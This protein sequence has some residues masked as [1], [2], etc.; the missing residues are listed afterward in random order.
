MTL[1]KEEAESIIEVVNERATE[2]RQLI[3]TIVSIIAIILPAAEGMGLVDL[4]PYGEGDDEWVVDDNWEMGSDF[5][6]GD[7]TTIQASLVD[8]G[9]KNCR[10]GSDEPDAPPIPP[11]S[12]NNTTVITEPP[13]NNN[14]NN[15]T[16]EEDCIAKM[17]D[18][19]ILD[20]NGT[21]LT[22][23]W[24][25]DL[26]CEEEAYN[27]TVVWTVYYNATGNFTSQN[28]VTYETQGSAWDYVNI[29]LANVTNGV[30]DIHSTF[31]LGDKYTRGTDWYAVEVN[32][33]DS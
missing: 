6:C 28:E 1:T 7:G 5:T 27:L 21:N 9:Y 19:Y 29:T 16:I 3:I 15:E 2:L 26:S 20:H 12:N 17:Y 23:T 8:D 13:N 22:I 4:T 18:A 25:A 24:D 10:D 11:P 30:Y 33:N 14:T 32:N 31:I